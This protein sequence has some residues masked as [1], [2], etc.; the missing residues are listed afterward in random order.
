MS[1]SVQLSLIW[2]FSVWEEHI[3][4]FSINMI[5][6]IPL[7][8]SDGCHWPNTMNMK[9]DLSLCCVHIPIIKF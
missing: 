6:C 7:D 3:F 4:V 8:I 2:V 9:S 5:V 1:L